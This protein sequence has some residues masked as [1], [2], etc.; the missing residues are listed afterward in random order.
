MTGGG[1]TLETTMLSGSQSTMRPGR[2]GQPGRVLKFHAPEIVFGVDSMV[3]AA[4]AA[5]RLGALRPMLITDP[6]LIEAGWVDE[7]LMHLRE[8][9][10]EAHV[11]SG[12]TPTPRTTRSRPA[13]RCTPSVAATSCWRWVAVR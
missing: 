8:Q 11:W 9:L 3:E 12:L 1:R 5:L 13:T 6:G 2:T 10:V 7:M 4:H